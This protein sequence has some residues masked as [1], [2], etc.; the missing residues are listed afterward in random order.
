MSQAGFELCEPGGGGGVGREGKTEEMSRAAFLTIGAVEAG[1][2]GGGGG[3][4]EG[5]RVLGI[6]GVLR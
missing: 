6:R 2:L 5:R 4:R 3:G 1:R